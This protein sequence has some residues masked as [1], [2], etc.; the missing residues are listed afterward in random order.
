MLWV[1]NLR[2]CMWTNYR[3]IVWPGMSPGPSVLQT[4][5]IEFSLLQAS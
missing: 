5:V 2:I 3:G 1:H 4:T